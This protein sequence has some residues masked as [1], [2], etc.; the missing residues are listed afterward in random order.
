MNTR[1]EYLSFIHNKSYRY[2]IFNKD[3]VSNN[4]L[5]RTYNM[6]FSKYR[7]MHFLF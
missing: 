5:L 7:S 2:I 6:N 1:H 4:S 3:L